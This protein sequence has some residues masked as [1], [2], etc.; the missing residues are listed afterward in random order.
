MK[1]AILGTRGI[2]NH[3]GGFEQFAEHLALGLQ[4][5]SHDVTVYSSHTHPY[6]ENTFHGVKII[7]IYDPEEKVG[8]AG[9]FVYDF[10]SIMDTRSQNYDIILQLGYTSSSIFFKLHPKTATLITNMD[11]LE[12]RRSKYSSKV[13][14]FLRWAE[15]LAVKQSHVLVSDS[16]GIQEYLHK[17]YTVDSTY[18]PYGAK[19]FKKPQ[20]EII[21]DYQLT[22]YQYN[23][24]IARL[25]P[26]NS[27]EIIL[28]GVSKANNTLPFLV[29]GNHNTKYGKYLKNRYKGKSNI[30]FLGGIY[31][32]NK[33]N[34]LRH[35]SKLYF[36]GHTVGGT[37][38]SLLEAMA[39]Q[40]LIC[41]HNNIFNAAILGI[42]SLYFKN[43]DDITTILN[44]LI[45]EIHQNKITNNIEKIKE[46]Y[47]YKSIIF[48]YEALFKRHLK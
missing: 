42:D 37:N 47:N 17:K 43:I 11:G 19:I 44:T 1:I 40:S 45:R 21:S 10:L 2:P 25:E 16:L 35:Y 3:Y 36:H 12:H 46:K 26:E 27:I 18:I 32:Q 39:S 29:I 22:P 6:K 15:S 13:Q 30:T 48:Q 38:P 31:D 14:T 5:R 4:Q 8:T 9:Q 28:D 41:A 33:L 20:E 34:N 7:H 23:L 24:L